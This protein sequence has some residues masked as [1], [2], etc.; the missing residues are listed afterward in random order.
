M[1]R[2]QSFLKNNRGSFSLEAVISMMFL[3]FL[4]WLGVAYYTYMTPQQVLTQEVHALATTAKLQ[5]GLTDLDVERFKDRLI[6]K[7]YVPEDKRDE[8]II[9]AVAEDE[10]GNEKTVLPV[11]PL[12]EGYSD[13]PHAYS[14]RGSKEIITVT[15]KIPAKIHFLKV[16]LNIWDSEPTEGMYHYVFQETVMSER[17]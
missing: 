12:S 8:I 17:W 16:V 7:G 4:I 11:L 1:K 3:L 2:I 5:G 9:T 6:E 10:Y 13:D 14:H 15:A